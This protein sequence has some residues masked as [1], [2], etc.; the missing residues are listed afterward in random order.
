MVLPLSP[1]TQNFAPHSL[2]RICIARND[3]KA[4]RQG[5]CGNQ[6][7]A[8][9]QGSARLCG[10]LAPG[11]SGAGIKIQ[12]AILARQIGGEG[13]NAAMIGMV[14]R[15]R[16]EALPCFRQSDRRNEQTGCV[17]AG[18]PFDDSL[19]RAR[20]SNFTDE[21][22]VEN[23]AHKDTCRTRSSGMRGISQ[24]V[25]LR[26]ESYQAMSCSMVRAARLRRRA[27]LFAPGVSSSCCS[28][29]RSFLACL[30]DRRLTSLMAISTALTSEICAH[31]WIGARFESAAKG[32]QH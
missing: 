30:G 18:V 25:V 3:A 31:R 4:S 21:I 17:L 12:N 19:V 7:V 16:V 29:A 23:E 26:M 20:L 2:K 8:Q 5:D 27:R 14:R 10:D 28:Q 13:L 24:S 11:S 15:E 22:R 9:R 1:G 32:S 6:R